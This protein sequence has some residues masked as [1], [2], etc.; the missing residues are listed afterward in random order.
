[1]V[2]TGNRQINGTSVDNMDVESR[3][4]ISEVSQY[5]S[6]NYKGHNMNQTTEAA[7]IARDEGRQRPDAGADPRSA[8]G[9]SSV[10]VV[11]AAG[12]GH[13]SVT[14]AARTLAKARQPKQQD[15]QHAAERA[16]SSR[17]EHAG[18]AAPAA[19]EFAFAADAATVNAA[20]RVEAPEAPG[21][22]Q[23]TDPAR[24]SPQGDDA[25]PIEPPRSWT[26]DT[27]D[28]WQ[29]LPRETQE[30]LAAREQE[31]DREIRRSQNEAADKLKGVT[32]REQ[33]AEQARQRYETALPNLLQTLQAQEAVEFP[34]IKTM[35]DVDRLA[36]EDWPRYMQ[37]DVAQ[38]RI[39]MATRQ[40]LDAYQRSGQL[41]SQ[42]FTD[43]A[44]RQDELFI[45]K[46]PDMADAGKAAA[47]QSA[48]MNVLKGLG[49]DEGELMQAWQGGKDLS[50]RDHR[51]QLLVRDATLWREAQQKAKA[52]S[53]RPVPPVQR[54]AVAQPK[55]AAQEAQIANLNKRLETASGN[56][57][58]RTA[59][60][61]L[62]AR[63]AGR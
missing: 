40:L 2:A 56:N 53:T 59:A 13:L 3:R 28:R 23:V 50:L 47:L 61:L 48:A 31:R 62:R 24:Q 17:D 30:Y 25:P 58:L 5:P 42:Q 32:A 45:E 22:T 46:A 29:S 8:S 57:A 7:G 39:A 27:K 33:Q 19:Q 6:C 51:V 38:K 10:T 55:A 52:A 20:P 26:K 44:K 54:P 41:K 63:R 18:A 1:M 37:W 60:E 4:G 49:F 15:Q 43:F 14:Q 21:E 11:T 12:D 36:R 9:H 16:S 34:D 35:G